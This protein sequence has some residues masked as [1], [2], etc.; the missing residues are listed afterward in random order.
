MHFQGGG[1]RQHA[2]SGQTASGLFTKE[3]YDALW[4]PVAGEVGFYS[5]FR[6][7]LVGSGFD[8]LKPINDDVPIATYTFDAPSEDQHIELVDGPA[9]SG[10]SSISSTIRRPEQPAG[11][12]SWS[13][14]PNKGG[15]RHRRHRQPPD[16]GGPPRQTTPLAT[17]QTSLTVDPWQRRRTPSMFRANPAGHPRPRSTAGGGN[18]L[19]HRRRPRA[20]G[21][22]FP[23]SSLTI[24]GGT[25]INTLRVDAPGG[26]GPLWRSPGRVQFGSPIGGARSGRLL[27][28]QQHPIPD[29]PSDAGRSPPVPGSRAVR[30]RGPDRR[31]GRDVSTASNLF[32]TAGTDFAATIDWGRRD[33]LGRP[34]SRPPRRT[35]TRAGAWR[36]VCRRSAPTS[37]PATA[38]MAVRVKH[39]PCPGGHVQLRRPPAPA[40]V[41]GR[42][43]APRSPPVHGAR[44]A[45]VNLKDPPAHG[46]KEAPSQA[47]RPARSFQG[48]GGHVSR[49]PGGGRTCRAATQPLLIN[50]G[51]GTAPTARPGPPT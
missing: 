46:G 42:V 44:P 2:E 29:G 33:P 31:R 15:R 51:D 7:L 19:D 35:R 24:D 45:P 47:H 5:G 12:S 14:T 36:H 37:T 21:H 32:L 48:G 23:P 27:Q 49:T 13:I 26:S 10:A 18:N 39:R 8:G 20:L 40:S 38:P 3:E 50:W 6:R 9:W 16:V 4:P 30:K 41:V 28:R 11:P 17:G 34:R 22:G 25:G 43:R 1:R